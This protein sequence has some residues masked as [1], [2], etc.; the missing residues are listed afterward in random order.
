MRVHLY[1]AGCMRECKYVIMYVLLTCSNCFVFLQQQYPVPT[2]FM[3]MVS[4][5]ECIVSNVPAVLPAPT[6]LPASH[7]AGATAAAAVAASRTVAS[8]PASATATA[9]L[10]AKPEVKVGDEAPTSTDSEQ[11]HITDK[12]PTNLSRKHHL[13]VETL[14]QHTYTCM[15]I[16]HDVHTQCRHTML[17]NFF[18]CRFKSMNMS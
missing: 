3:P 10:S 1:L 6:A 15:H 13:L 8:P 7:T 4:G 11:F 2:S 17:N 14:C 5:A 9:A 18:I 16:K 12:Y